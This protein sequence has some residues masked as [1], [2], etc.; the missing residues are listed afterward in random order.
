MSLQAS[1][2]HLLGGALC[3]DFANSTNWSADE[4]PF[5]LF[6]DYPALLQWS[7]QLGVF[8]LPQAERLMQLASQRDPEA[9][10]VLEKTRRLRQAI[11]RIFSCAADGANAPDEDL[12]LL[13]ATLSEA[14]PNRQVRSQQGGFVWDWSE[15]SPALDGLLWRVAQ[16]AGDLLTSEQ[17]KRVKRCD[18]CGW[19]FLD[20]TRG[21]QRRWCDMSI[22][23]NRAKARRYYARGKVEA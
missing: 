3:L 4:K 20:T 6:W 21:G 7:L 18:G 23:G 11:Y 12:A 15:D 10:A 19:L 14:L 17:L 5:D 9:Q 8:N 22:C 13:N 16:S 1:N 2:F